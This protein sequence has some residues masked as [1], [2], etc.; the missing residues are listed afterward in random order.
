[1]NTFSSAS[2]DQGDGVLVFLISSFEHGGFEWRGG[3]DIQIINVDSRDASSY[4]LEYKEGSNT[5]VLVKP[6][7]PATIR[8]DKAVFE[9]SVTVRAL[10][11]GQDLVRSA[12][13]NL[14]IERRSQRIV[15]QFPSDVNLTETPFLNQVPRND[16]GTIKAVFKMVV[17]KAPG[18][19]VKGTATSQIINRLCWRLADQSKAVRLLVQVSNQADQ[20]VEDAYAGLL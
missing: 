18:L 6:I 11:T 10:Q 12:F 17:Y 20:A 8:Q 3:F 15:L 7:L 1:M 2:G 5:A 16:G 9:K 14:P 4:Y 13:E 19:P